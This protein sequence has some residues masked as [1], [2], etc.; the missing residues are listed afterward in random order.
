MTCI[1]GILLNLAN[2]LVNFLLGLHFAN[3]RIGVFKQ[4]E[5]EHT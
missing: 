3:Q 4:T 2:R 5:N 1:S